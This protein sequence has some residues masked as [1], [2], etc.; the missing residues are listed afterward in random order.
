MQTTLINTRFNFLNKQLN[1][2]K[3]RITEILLKSIHYKI[4]VHKQYT[5][6]KYFHHTLK[7]SKA[8]KSWYVHFRFN[9]KQ[10]RLK[11]NIN[12]ITV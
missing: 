8:A 10:Y 1:L 12:R 11:E 6:E 3:I 2:I 9:G 7:L 5:N 4:T